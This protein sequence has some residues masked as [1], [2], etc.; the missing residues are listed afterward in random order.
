MLQVEAHPAEGE[1]GLLEDHI[2]ATGSELEAERPRLAELVGVQG[3]TVTR[4]TAL[5]APRGSAVL[6]TQVLDIPELVLGWGDNQDAHQ[7]PCVVRRRDTNNAHRPAQPPVLDPE[8]S[9]FVS[10]QHPTQHQV[11]ET[12]DSS[13]RP[14]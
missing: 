6:H 3:V 5:G 2:L 9:P 7:E 12:T 8:R 14:S 10:C 11:L 1:P 4:H 13:S